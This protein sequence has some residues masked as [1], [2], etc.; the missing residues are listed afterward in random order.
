MLGIKRRKKI[1]K[2]RKNLFVLERVR[3]RNK[4]EKLRNKEASK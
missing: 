3:E 1:K 4:E 2:F